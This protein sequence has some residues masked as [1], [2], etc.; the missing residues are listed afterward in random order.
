L[1]ADLQQ[2]DAAA[3]IA[4]RRAGEIVEEEREEIWL[5]YPGD[6]GAGVFALEPRLEESRVLMLECTFL[7]E[8]HRERAGRYGHLHFEDLAAF[9]PRSRNEAIVVYHLS[10]RHPA[11][12]LRALI[13]QRLPE[14]ASRIH[15]F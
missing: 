12:E 10:R 4:R 14:L 6:T 13:D 2:E 3:I 7:A 5:S 15:L 9:A 8:S 1:R 11:A